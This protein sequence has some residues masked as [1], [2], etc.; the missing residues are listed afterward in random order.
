MRTLHFLLRL[1]L[2]SFN[3]VVADF[4]E[5][6]ASWFDFN[7]TTALHFC[8]GP[9]LS[10]DHPELS[11]ILTNFLKLLLFYDSFIFSFLDQLYND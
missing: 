8:F 6:A 11:E 2:H 4:G 1:K 7:Q 9:F 10:V 3:Q 5:L